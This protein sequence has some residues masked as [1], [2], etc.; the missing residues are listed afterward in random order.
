MG[1]G[2]QRV[3]MFWMMLLGK[4]N[5]VGRGVII[6]LGKRREEAVADFGST[7]RCHGSA[8]VGAEGLAGH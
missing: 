7:T 3:D 1:W 2:D 4:T 5:L 8:S 6:I